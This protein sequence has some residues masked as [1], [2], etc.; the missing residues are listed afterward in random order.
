[1]SLGTG[2]DRLPREE[3]HLHLVPRI[4]LKWFPWN[5]YEIKKYNS[6]NRFQNIIMKNKCQ[7]MPYLLRKGVMVGFE[8]KVF[9]GR[10][11]K[12]HLYPAA[13]PLYC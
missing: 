8:K 9:C 6:V 1:M 5:K 3:N 2:M 7:L 12:L 13:F 11:A 10:M 4:S